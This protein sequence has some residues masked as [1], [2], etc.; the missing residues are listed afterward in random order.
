MVLNYKTSSQLRYFCFNNYKNLE[1]VSNM[2]GDDV[3][4]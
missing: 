3:A 2:D 4:Q 1:L